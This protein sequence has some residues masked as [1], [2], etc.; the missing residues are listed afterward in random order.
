M[1]TKTLKEFLPKCLR[2]SKAGRLTAPATKY[3]CDLNRDLQLGYAGRV[4][5]TPAVL[6]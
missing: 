5:Y 4:Q 6:L 1:A 2:D 3:N